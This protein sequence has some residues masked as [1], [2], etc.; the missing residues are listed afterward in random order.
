MTPSLLTKQINPS[1]PVRFFDW[2]AWIDGVEEY[3]AHGTTEEEA[4]EN[5]REKLPHDDEGEPKYSWL[6]P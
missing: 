3:N 1:I 5:L 6:A 2:V 4:I